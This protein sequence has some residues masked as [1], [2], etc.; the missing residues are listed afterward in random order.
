[1]GQLPEAVGGRPCTAHIFGH[2]FDCRWAK[3]SGLHPRWSLMAAL[4]QPLLLRGCS[5]SPLPLPLWLAWTLQD[6]QSC[7]QGP[8]L[9]FLSL[10]WGRPLWWI[11]LSPPLRERKPRFRVPGTPATLLPL[12]H[13]AG[14]PWKPPLPLGG[15]KA[16]LGGKV[17]DGWTPPTAPLASCSPLARL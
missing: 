6:P 13:G 3:Q 5:A 11:L 7:K 8:A 16:P 2:L 14:L 15:Q 17:S 9:A 4:G 10:T 1:M 12:N